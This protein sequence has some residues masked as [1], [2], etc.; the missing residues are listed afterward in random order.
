MVLAKGSL[1]SLCTLEHT[2]SLYC[3]RPKNILLSL[4]NLHNSIQN[5][6]IGV[7]NY[8]IGVSKKK[9]PLYPT[10]YTITVLVLVK[11]KK[12]KKKK[13]SL[14]SCIQQHT[15]L[16]YWCCYCRCV[17]NSTRNYRI[18]VSKKK[19]HYCRCVSNSTRNYR[20]GVSNNKKREKK[21]LLSLCIQ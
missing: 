17:S 9:S 19:S 21:S 13:K 4:C 3:Y 7:Q 15:K 11:K 6:R 12:K 14:L 5:Y 1:L 18:G 10:A 8:C 2:K 20:I 16:P